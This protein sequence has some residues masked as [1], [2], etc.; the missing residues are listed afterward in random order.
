MTSEL[1]KRPILLGGL[2][3]TA[4][5]W[6]LHGIDP[7]IAHFG[8]T[9]VWSAIAVGSGLWWFKQ[10]NKSE[11]PIPV[12]QKI[13]RAAVEQAFQATRLQIDQLAQEFTDS[14]TDPSDSPVAEPEMIQALRQ[15]LADLGEDLDRK[16]VRL[17][18]LGSQAVGK[19]TIDLGR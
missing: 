6:L 13:D 11:I 10:T 4:G 15:R 9:A 16:S 12:I 8:S 2:G 5:A 3:L 7:G 19:T 1:L 17:A 18:I 14:K